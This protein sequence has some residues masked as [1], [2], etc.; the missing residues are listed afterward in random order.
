MTVAAVIILIIQVITFVALGDPVHV[1]GSDATRD[2]PDP[3]R[4][5]SDRD[6]HRRNHQ[7]DR[8]HHSGRD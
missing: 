6:L 7:L 2:R 8:H 1:F 4:T 5:G 3:S